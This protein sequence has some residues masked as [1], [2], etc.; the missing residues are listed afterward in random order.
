[1]PRT[2]GKWPHYI[3]SS[4]DEATYKWLQ[5]CAIEEQSTISQVLRK[6]LHYA[7]LEEDM[8]AK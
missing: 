6:I 3:S 1:M 4:V 8:D 7:K 2:A 5:D